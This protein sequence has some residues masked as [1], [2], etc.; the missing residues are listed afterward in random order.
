MYGAF[1]RYKHL[2][3]EE[4]QQQL[5]SALDAYEPMYTWRSHFIKEFK[6]DPM[7]WAIYKKYRLP[8]INIINKAQQTGVKVNTA[9]LLE[10]QRIYQDRLNNIQEEA[11]AITGDDNFNIG[12]KNKMM[13]YIYE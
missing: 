11:K 5:Y 1:N 7:S 6:E 10:V 12:G 2:I 3:H 13:E 8:L 9:R 4:E